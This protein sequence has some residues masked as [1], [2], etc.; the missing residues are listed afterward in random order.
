MRSSHGAKVAAEFPLPWRVPVRVWPQ[1]VVHHFTILAPLDIFLPQPAVVRAE[2]RSGG[3]A[4][5]GEASGPHNPHTSSAIIHALRHSRL[6]VRQKSSVLVPPRAHVRQSST[7]TPHAGCR[8]LLRFAAVNER[9]R[10]SS[11][12]LAMLQVQ[13]EQGTLRGR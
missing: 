9:R 1:W 7:K 5:V 10:R 2:A 3:A 11:S 8:A 12:A 6:N 13:A 4:G